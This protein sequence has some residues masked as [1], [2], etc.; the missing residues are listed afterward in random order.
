MQKNRKIFKNIAVF[1]TFSLFYN[2]SSEAIRPKMFLVHHWQTKKILTL[3]RALC[4]GPI[5]RYLNYRR[6]GH[7]GHT[8][9]LDVLEI[10]KPFGAKE[11]FKKF[12]YDFFI[13][14]K[15][16]LYSLDF[17]IDLNNHNDVIISLILKLTHELQ[18]CFYLP[19]MTEN[20][21]RSIKSQQKQ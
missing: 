1:F 2:I 7:G 20:Q 8:I 4:V 19:F 3:K 11:I 17:V 21:I 6:T 16:I 18:T 12:W 9:F 10:S 14:T 13:W 15:H 5:K